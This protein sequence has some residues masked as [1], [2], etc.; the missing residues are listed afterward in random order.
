MITT[1]IEQQI[2]ETLRS[3]KDNAVGS[4]YLERKFNLSRRDVCNAIENL[5]NSG[6]PIGAVR[7][8]NGGYYIIDSEDDLQNALAQYNSQIHKMLKIYNN[9][10]RHSKMTG[11]LSLFEVEHG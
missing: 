4:K 10:A 5:R 7:K 8:K 11:Q 6:Y 1:T 9:L 3:G 2:Y